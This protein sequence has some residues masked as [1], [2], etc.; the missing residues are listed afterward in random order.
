MDNTGGSNGQVVPRVPQWLHNHVYVVS[1]KRFVNTV[2]GQL[3]DKEQFSDRIGPVSV[4]KNGQTDVYDPTRFFFASR[5]GHIA[6]V[7]TFR[8][9][10]GLIVRERGLSALNVY[11]PPRTPSMDGDAGT[12]APWLALGEHII[13]D[14]AA[15]QH[16]LRYFAHLIQHPEQKV[17]HGLLLLSIE[18]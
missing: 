13:P 11:R 14:A 8:P 6:D 17:N 18:Q 3:L 10:Q 2:T 7:L 9:G 5:R 12:V 15:R 16:H 4:K 1:I